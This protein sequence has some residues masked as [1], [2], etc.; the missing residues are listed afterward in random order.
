[1]FLYFKVILSDEEDEFEAV[2]IEEE[3][4]YIEYLHQRKHERDVAFANE[5]LPGTVT[6]VVKEHQKKDD[7][8]RF[9]DL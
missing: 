6:N 5:P 2:S 9:Y 3:L 1:M 4:E 8:Q 7:S